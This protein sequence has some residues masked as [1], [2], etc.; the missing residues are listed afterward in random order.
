MG[1]A[2]WLGWGLPPKLV[3]TLNVVLDEALNNIISYGYREAA[4]D[5][6]VVYLAA[7]PGEIVAEIEDGVPFDP[8]KVPAPDLDAPLKDRK[9][10][11]L[12]VHCMRSLMDYVSHERVA[13]R[14]RLRLTQKIHPADI[15]MQPSRAT[16]WK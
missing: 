4:N 5:E 16:H 14:N 2:L 9:V 12:G 11:G 10:G 8:L 1:R 7:T 3:E 15:P 13:G 6:I